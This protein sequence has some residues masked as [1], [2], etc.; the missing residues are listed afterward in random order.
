MAIFTFFVHPRKRTSTV[1]IFFCQTLPLRRYKARVHCLQF[2]V[3]H[4]FL[5]RESDY[6][7]KSWPLD[8]RIP[9]NLLR[10]SSILVECS[11]EKFSINNFEI[12]KT[13]KKKSGTNFKIQMGWVGQAVLFKEIN[14]CAL[15]EEHFT[16]NHR[17]DNKLIHT[18]AF[19]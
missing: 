13:V 17:K 8:E 11:T 12:K 19:L 6:K 10:S 1:C 16:S 3:R 15:L 7:P 14:S 18:R 9:Y 4:C 2:N 5:D